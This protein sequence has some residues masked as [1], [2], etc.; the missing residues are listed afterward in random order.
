V[1][2]TLNG[3]VPPDSEGEEMGCFRT[4]VIG[5][6]CGS[7]C[8]W[9]LG[10]LVSDTVGF[11]MKNGSY[12]RFEWSSSVKFLWVATGEGWFGGGMKWVVS[13]VAVA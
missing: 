2:P 12:G 13:W 9:P 4:R 11:E 8:F 10:L 6:F 3:Q 7:F 1:V 5:P